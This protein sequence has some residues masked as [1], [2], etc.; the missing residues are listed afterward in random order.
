MPVMQLRHIISLTML[1]LLLAAC[2]ASQQ[3]AERSKQQLIIGAWRA[4]S[5]G[6]TVTLVYRENQVEVREFGATFRYAWVDE[7]H[8]RLDALGQEVVTRVDFDSPDLM[9]QTS[10]GATQLLHRLP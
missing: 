1:A 7:D 9:R 8:I 2:T 10:Q 3:D 6:Q 5:Q 4:D